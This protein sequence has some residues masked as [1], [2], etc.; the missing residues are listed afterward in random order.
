M[1]HTYKEKLEMKR[2]WLLPCILILLTALVACTSNDGVGETTDG[3]KIERVKANLTL[4][5]ETG[6]VYMTITNNT[7]EDEKLVAA[8]VPGCAAVELH[9]MRMDGDVMTMRQV[10]GG[11]IAIPAGEM[12]ELKQG[13]LHIMCIGKTGEFTVG[14]TVPVTLEFAKAGTMEVQAEVIAPGELQMDH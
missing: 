12:V 13:G 6:A 8:S 3:L 11:E 4:P 2:C 14:D 1:S 7:D 10:E 9:E 5:T